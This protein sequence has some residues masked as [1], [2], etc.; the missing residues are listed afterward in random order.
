MERHTQG[1][2]QWEEIVVAVSTDGDDFV[3]RT[4]FAAAKSLRGKFN[5]WKAVL[6]RAVAQ[7]ELRQV[8][9]KAALPM[10]LRA[11][12]L[13]GHADR[14]MCKLE[15]VE[16]VDLWEIRWQNKDKAGSELLKGLVRVK[17]EGVQVPKH[18]MD[19]IQ[20]AAKRM[21]EGP[22]AEVLSL[23]Q[24]AIEKSKAYGA[25]NPG[26]EFSS[27]EFLDMMNPDRKKVDKDQETE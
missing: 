7:A 10:D 21:L 6:R 13:A 4:S 16:G 20:A 5:N 12:E 25:R 18:E 2:T 17:G 9:G 8:K 15:Q 14:T 24:A 23:D 19:V 3:L 26:Q 11:I 27:K 22:K 1:L